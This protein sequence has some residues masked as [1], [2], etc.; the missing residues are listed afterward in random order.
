[1]KINF[2]ALLGASLILFG[3]GVHAQSNYPN[4]TVT[5]PRQTTNQ[6]ARTLGTQDA[7]TQS[8]SVR[9]IANVCGNGAT[10]WPTCTITTTGTENQTIACAAPQ[11]G[12]INQSRTV[13]YVNGVAT[14]YGAWTTTSS[15]C[16]T[17]STTTTGT[18]NQTLNCPAPQTGTI[19]QTRTV[20]YVNGVATSYSPWTTVTSNCANN[21]SGTETQT[22]SCPAPQ[23]GSIAQS[24][25]V[26]YSN[27]VATSYGPWTTTS[28]NCVNT[29]TNN[30]SQTINCPA[31]QTGNIWQTRTVT[32]TNGVQTSATPWTD[33]GNNCVTP[34]PTCTP[35]GVDKCEGVNFVTRN[36]CTGDIWNVV[37][38]SPTCGGCTPTNVTAC[39]GDNSVTRNSC[40]NTIVSVN[41][42][43][44]YVAPPDPLV[45]VYQFSY[46]NTNVSTFQ[47]PQSQSGPYSGCS[48]WGTTDYACV[49]QWS[50]SGA[51][52]L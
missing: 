38:N 39:E 48:P 1:M 29:T 47:I 10:N 22:I 51:C 40:D 26:T 45:T 2:A 27:G 19:D 31:P 24:R 49:V 28:S 6:P 52:G 25:T 44:C 18:E 16:S 50:G 32:Y 9:T 30:E 43:A 35:T 12:S 34:P 3:V 8:D 7:S 11:V 42:G 23:T 33:N 5:E 46:C 14:S 13:T 37:W 36:A 4:G 17:P 20:T 15:N 41:W 21:T